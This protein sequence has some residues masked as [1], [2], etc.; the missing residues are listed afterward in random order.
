MAA[1]SKLLWPS[2]L[3]SARARRHAKVESGQLQQSNLMRWLA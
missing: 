3:S 2:C 1:P